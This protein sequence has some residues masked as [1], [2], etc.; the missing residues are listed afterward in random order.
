MN[1]TFNKFSKFQRGIIYEFLKDGYSFECRY[2][3]DWSKNWK[4]ADDFFYDNLQ[5]ADA[6]GFVTT[7]NEI[8]IG[9]TKIQSK[10]GVY[11]FQEIGGKVN[12]LPKED[13]ERI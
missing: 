13:W 12:E 9:F 2:E 1:V 4:E 10:E 6:C 5:I 8:P 11:Y 7:L 3:R